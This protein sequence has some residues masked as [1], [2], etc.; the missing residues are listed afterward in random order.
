MSRY[1]DSYIV[2][3]E[4]DATFEKLVDDYA[5][6]SFIAGIYTAMS[7]I[8]AIPAADV[9]PVIHAHWIVFIDEQGNRHMKCSNCGQYWSMAQNAKTFKR[10]FA[11][12]A[13]M[14]E[15]EGQNGVET[16]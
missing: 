3:N 8:N 9:E 4:V 13:K 12:G 1:I 15:Q 7:N 11:C 6:T 16:H 2:K 10:C 5:G 14:D